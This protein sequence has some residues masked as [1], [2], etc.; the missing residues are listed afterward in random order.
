MALI[1]AGAGV[2]LGLPFSI[3]LLPGSPSSMNFEA[4]GWYA[5]FVSTFVA[6]FQFLPYW[7]YRDPP[8]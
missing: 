2:V 6:L 7:L 4:A 8:A 1:S 3:R 5:V